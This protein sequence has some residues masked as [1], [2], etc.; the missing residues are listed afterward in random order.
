MIYTHSNIKKFY[1]FCLMRQYLLTLDSSGL[2]NIKHLKLCSIACKIPYN[3]LRADLSWFVAIGVL[4]RG[5][6]NLK[7]I[8]LGKQ[9]KSLYGLYIRYEGQISQSNTPAIYFADLYKRKKIHNNIICQIKREATKCDPINGKKLL[10][11]VKTSKAKI[12][13]KQGVYLSL[14]TIGR[15]FGRSKTTAYK[16][17]E[18]LNLNGI[19]KRIRNSAFICHLSEYQYH[20]KTEKL[21]GRLFVRSGKVYERLLNSYMFIW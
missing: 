1:R 19:V 6:N 18:R 9:Y 15:L 2:Y 7:L 16:Y 20:R 12:G 4:W 21:Y 5:R 11:L 10:K 3:T 14:G 13:E 8:R 17:I